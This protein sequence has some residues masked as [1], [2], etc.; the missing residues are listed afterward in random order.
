MTIVPEGDGFKVAGRPR[1]GGDE[2]NE[3][4]AKREREEDTE[5][6]NKRAR[7]DG[8]EEP[9][10]HPEVTCTKPDLDD[11][12]PEKEKEVVAS[13]SASTTPDKLEGK[14]DIFLSEGV[15]ENLAATLD[16][17]PPFLLISHR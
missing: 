12:V 17:S 10:T 1:T 14:G 9:E 11:A 7:L 3:G 8:R 5:E 16:V 13:A 2:V 15:R 4:R 6:E